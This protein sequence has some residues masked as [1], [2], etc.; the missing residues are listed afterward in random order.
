[1]E[2]ADDRAHE[3]VAVGPRAHRRQ[4]PE[5]PVACARGHCRQRHARQRAPS[6]SKAKFEN[7]TELL[8]DARSI[9][10]AEEVAW[11]E[12]AAEILDQVVAAILA[13]ARPGVMENEM[14]ATIW[15]TIIANG[16]DYPS[17]THWGAGAGVPWACRIAPHRPLQAG[18]FIK[19]GT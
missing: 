14:V 5:R 6:V 18:D 10:G 8:Q 12:R 19:H 1:M 15:Q 13:K 2:S 9:K 16:G 17:M 3:G 4:R 11:M 7:A